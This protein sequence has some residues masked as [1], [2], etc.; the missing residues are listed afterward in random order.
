MSENTCSWLTRTARHRAD[1]DG[2]K[3][4]LNRSPHNRETQKSAKNSSTRHRPFRDGFQL[5][6]AVG[7]QACVREIPGD[8]REDRVQALNRVTAGQGATAVAGIE[9]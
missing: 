7:D 5:R 9:V 3:Q 8:R 1:D 4:N 6:R 2:Q